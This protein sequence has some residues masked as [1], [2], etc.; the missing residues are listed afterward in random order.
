[1]PILS[2][3]ISIQIWQCARMAH[4]TKTQG[5]SL[6]LVTKTLRKKS[7]TEK[8]SEKQG[9]EDKAQE[10]HTLSSDTF[11]VDKTP[12]I[13][14]SRCTGH[15]VH[16]RYK[17]PFPFCVNRALFP[18]LGVTLCSVC[19]TTSTQRLLKSRSLRCTPATSIFPEVSLCRQW[20]PSHLVP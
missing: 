14:V 5:D 3:R 6:L 7:L 2:L 1:M 4:T 9:A 16:S 20:L 17:I 18:S 12:T 11:L 10:R 15:P 13:R 19:L 8:Q